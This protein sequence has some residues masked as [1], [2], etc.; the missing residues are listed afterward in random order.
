MFYLLSAVLLGGMAFLF[1]FYRSA[2]KAERDS[3]AA[4]QA[5]AGKEVRKNAKAASDRIDTSDIDDVRERLRKF[6]RDGD[7]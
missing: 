7:A 1:W 5:K 4:Q 6:A 3:L 2:K